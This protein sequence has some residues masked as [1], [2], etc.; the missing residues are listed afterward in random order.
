MR[1][2]SGG[3]AEYFLIFTDPAASASSTVSVHE[4]A[5]GKAGNS[6]R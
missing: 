2:R 6:A 3:K 1:E 4:K 5:G